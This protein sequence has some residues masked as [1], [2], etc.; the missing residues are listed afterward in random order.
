MQILDLL[1]S[2]L[3]TIGWAKEVLAIVPFI[4]LRQGEVHRKV[5]PFEKYC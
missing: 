1:E 2:G 5:Q 4:V 3:L